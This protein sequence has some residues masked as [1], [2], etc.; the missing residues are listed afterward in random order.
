MIDEPFSAGPSFLHTLDPRFRLVMATIF[1]LTVALARR[2]ETALAGLFC[3]ALL[4]E[5]IS[6][7]GK[8]TGI[9]ERFLEEK[10]FI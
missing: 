10:G 9:S 1:S 5:K 3:A 6:G 7:I 4:L 2:P 8:E